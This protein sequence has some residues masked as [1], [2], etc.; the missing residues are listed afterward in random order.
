MFYWQELEREQ[1]AEVYD[2]A[3]ATIGTRLFRARKALQD[4]LDAAITSERRQPEDFDA[5]AK[6]LRGE[7]RAD[8]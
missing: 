4:R 7:T 2:V 8:G 6:S 3:E 5:W 1:I